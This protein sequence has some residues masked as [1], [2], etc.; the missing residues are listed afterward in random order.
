MHDK[1]RDEKHQISHAQFD[2]T[3]QKGKA[4][5]ILEMETENDINLVTQSTKENDEERLIIFCPFNTHPLLPPVCRQILNLA[6]FW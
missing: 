1:F 4:Y 2:H 3:S 6:M 5:H